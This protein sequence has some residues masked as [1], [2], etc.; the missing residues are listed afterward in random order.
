MAF[1]KR[2]ALLSHLATKH[3]IGEKKNQCQ[4]CDKAFYRSTTLRYH[5]KTHVKR[6]RNRYVCYICGLRFSYKTLLMNHQKSHE[7]ESAEVINESIIIDP[8][9]EGSNDTVYFEITEG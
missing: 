1:G 2:R 3:G 8:T 5:M 4:L 7:N 9:L 6:D